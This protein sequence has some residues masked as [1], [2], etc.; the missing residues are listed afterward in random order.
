MWV[1]TRMRVV[2][3]AGLEYWNF[4]AEQLSW[5]FRLGAPFLSIPPCAEE[6]RIEFDFDFKPTFWQRVAGWVYWFNRKGR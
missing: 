5:A 4:S 1:I 3:R 2:N 6:L